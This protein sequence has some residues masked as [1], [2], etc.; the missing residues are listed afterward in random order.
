MVVLCSIKMMSHAGVCGSSPSG[1]TR[2]SVVEMGA[3]LILDVEWETWP[4]IINFSVP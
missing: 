2:H 4:D 1:G 3:G